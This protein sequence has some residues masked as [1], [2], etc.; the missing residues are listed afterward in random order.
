[1]GD[2]DDDCNCEGDVEMESEEE[3]LLGEGWRKREI[4]YVGRSA[5]RVAG[6][7]YLR[8]VDTAR[9]QYW[10]K[11]FIYSEESKNGG[12]ETPSVLSRRSQG[13]SLEKREKRLIGGS[14]P[15]RAAPLPLAG[16]SLAGRCWLTPATADDISTP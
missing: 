4:A 14:K 5:K 1:M 6:G 8:K 2:F 11:G 12:L 9:R 15:L 16:L 3:G 7:R 10:E 13:R